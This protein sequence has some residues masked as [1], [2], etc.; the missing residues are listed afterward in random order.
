M[1]VSDLLLA[2]GAALLG[3]LLAVV[4]QRLILRSK[5]RHGAA[6]IEA[7]QAARRSKGTY[8]GG[9]YARLAARRGA[10][11][12]AVAVGHSILISAYHLLKRRDTYDDLGDAYF[13]RR[14]R[15]RAERRL[16]HRLEAL[17]F[18]VTLDAAGPAA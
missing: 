9:Q 10:K 17:G 11:K 4:V 14:D 13:A 6:L 16:V 15:E 7:A 18:R 3:I 5:S 8:L 12:A 2:G 1:S